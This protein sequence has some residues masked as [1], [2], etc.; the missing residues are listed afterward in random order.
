[1]HVLGQE[2]PVHV[3]HLAA[4]LSMINW[5]GTVCHA[6][7]RSSAAQ[8]YSSCTRR[9]WETIL[10]NAYITYV[11]RL[12]VLMGA[13]VCACKGAEILISLNR[14]FVYVPYF[15]ASV[16]GRNV[17]FNVNLQLIYLQLIHNDALQS[18]GS[19]CP[20]TEQTNWIRGW[21][22]ARVYMCVRNTYMHACTL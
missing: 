13:H 5:N 15:F 18:I 3:F 9:A 7:H 16:L 2:N 14:C 4:L 8:Q 17:A 21:L 6:R 22:S 20:S 11:R 12:H 19:V 10:R 1:M